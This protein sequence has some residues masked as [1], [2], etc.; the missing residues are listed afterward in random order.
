MTNCGDRVAGWSRLPDE[1]PWTERPWPQ[2]YWRRRWATRGVVVPL[3]HTTVS[4]TRRHTAPS[5][6]STRAAQKS[7]RPCTTLQSVIIVRRHIRLSSAFVPGARLASRHVFASN[8]ACSF[9]SAPGVIQAL[10]TLTLHGGL[11][12]TR[13]VHCVFL[14]CSAMCRRT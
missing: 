8:P 1:K 11:Q 4:C 3:R 9:C 13:V 7:S 10:I 12:H 6:P 5:F 14:R 2:T